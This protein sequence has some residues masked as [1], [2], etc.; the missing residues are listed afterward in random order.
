LCFTVRSALLGGGTPPIGKRG[1]D[2]WPMMPAIRWL[3]ERVLVTMLQVLGSEKRQNPRR[4]IQSFKRFIDR[5]DDGIQRL[6]V[7]R[8]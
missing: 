5:D 7:R 8:L 6:G 3:R 4:Q 2:N 1:R